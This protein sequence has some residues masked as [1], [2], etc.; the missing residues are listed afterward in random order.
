PLLDA[1]PA[2]ALAFIRRIRSAL[3]PLPRSRLLVRAADATAGRPL[4]GNALRSMADAVVDVYPLDALRTW[5]PGWYSD[6]RAAPLVAVGD[7]DCRRCLV[8]LEHR[9][10]LG[11]IGHELALFETDKQLRPVFSAVPIAEPAAQP[12]TSA[13][14]DSGPSLPPAEGPPAGLPFNLGLTDKQRQ[15]RA[16]V[17]LPYLQAQLADASISE[18]RPAAGGEIHYQ[19]D[20]E[21]DW[22]EDDPDDDLEI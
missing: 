4:D 10:Q 18:P 5:L 19:P 2:A 9:K 1:S 21:D 14:G 12:A 15:D 22:D 7:N 20:A 16:N 11:K 6:G 13:A 8:R 17:E 3:L